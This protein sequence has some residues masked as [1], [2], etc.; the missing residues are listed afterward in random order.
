MPGVITPVPFENTAVRLVLAPSVIVVGLAAKLV[1]VGAGGA[2]PDP[3]PVR[4]PKHKLTAKAHATHA[5]I[6]PI[7]IPVYNR[8]K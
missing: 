1:I 3:Q 5:E 6:R 7:F 2:L 8:V 4:P